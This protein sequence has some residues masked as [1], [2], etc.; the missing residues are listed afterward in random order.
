M[1]RK[2]THRR[3]PHPQEAPGPAAKKRVPVAPPAATATAVAPA[4]SKRRA[5]F[6]LAAVLLAGTLI[7]LL[8]LSDLSLW[9]D[10]YVHVM[11][12]KGFLEGAGPLLTDDNNG[13][14]LTLCLLPGFAIFG[15]TVFWARFPN[16]L[17]GVGLIYLVYRMGA[18]L[19][20]RYVGLFAASAA[21][22]SLFLIFWSRVC[23]NYAPLAF[24]YLLLGLVFRA[25]FERETD[26]K[27]AGW[28]AGHGVSG[29]HL[30]LLPVAGVLALLS[31]QLAFFFRIFSGC[32]CFGPFC[33][34]F[35][36]D[37]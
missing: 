23:R 34:F 11:R 37:R 36:D 6:G 3:A 7:R 5:A 8:H 9:M 12:A 27:P 35:S 17:F 28:W 22:L 19:F 15:P 25:A 1:T 20:N 33:H 26:R 10:E 32:L 31:H 29:R 14:L 2:K 16:V 24:F 13:I 30:A 21:T 4:F 18:R